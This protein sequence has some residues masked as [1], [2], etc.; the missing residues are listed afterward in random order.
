MPFFMPPSVSRLKDQ[1][2]VKGL[3]KALG[4]QKDSWVRMDAAYALADIG[5]AARAAI[6]ALIAAL[7]NDDLPASHALGRIGPVAVPALIAALG[8]EN[9][10]VRANAAFALAYMGAPASG[11]VPALIIALED[12]DHLVQMEA[13][14]ALG[15]IGPAAAEAIPA[16]KAAARNDVFVADWAL[17][18]ILGE[19]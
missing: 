1:R 5:P 7:A 16:L 13:A 11:A 8:D 9:A 6:P 2:D 3:I 15:M 19:D 12:N 10:K 17:K 14:L 4:Y 18:R